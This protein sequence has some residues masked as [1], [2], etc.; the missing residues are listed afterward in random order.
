MRN[1]WRPSMTNISTDND[2]TA[3][4]RVREG[5]I[6]GVIAY[7]LWGLFPL[8]LKLLSSVS[9]LEI[10]S[11]RILWSVPFAALLLLARS[12]WPEVK[13][14]ITDKRVMAALAIAAIAISANWLIYVWAVI[15][16]Q[17]LQASLGYYINPLMYVA[18]GVFILGENLRRA[19]IAAVIIATIGVLVMTLGAGVFPWVAISLA[20]L[21]TAYGY[22]RK[23][24]NIGALP[25]L[26]IEVCMLSPIA[27]VY[28]LWMMKAG[29][30]MFLSGN[31]GLDMLLVFAGPVTVIPLVC[32]ALAARRLKLST[33]GF[34]QYIGPTF[35]F[36]LGI[37]FGE[38]FTPAHG[39]AFGLIWIGLAIF[40][41]DAARA[42]RKV[43][44]ARDA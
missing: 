31:S 24:A 18:A 5:L 38:T 40:S 1:I 8:F 10:L 12:Q 42:N 15:N 6:F 25:G 23:M 41:I 30:A 37:Y 14:A 3:Q 4:L 28:L 35:Q 44:P 21:F 17:I 34:L 9:A 11:H 7:T 22:I 29:E 36:A 20:A 43:I 16:D 39:V 32:F 2:E 19:Q 27:L 26:F 33:L 13:R